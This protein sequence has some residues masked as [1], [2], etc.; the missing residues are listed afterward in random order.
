MRTA[1]DILADRVKDLP[2]V[3]RRTAIFARM[4]GNL[5]VVNTGPTTIS[6]PCVGFYPPIPG[7]AVQL[8]RTAGQWKVTGPAVAQPAIGTISATGTPQATVTIG[9]KQ[10][11]LYYRSGYTPSIGD[12]VE[13]NWATGVIQGKITG[14]NTGTDP[15]TNPGGGAT[16]LPTSP[17]LASDSGQFRSRWQGNDPRASDSVSGAWVYNG[18]VAAAL[19]GA[20][21]T[22]SEIYLPL[23]AQLGVCNIGVHTS[24]TL[25]SGWVGMSLSTPLNP[26]GGWVTLPLSFAATLA[27]GGGISVASGNGDNQWAGTQSD[28]LSGALRFQGTR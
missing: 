2:D 16:P 26:R 17:I 20:T 11:Q 6:I 15:G 13:V 9:G 19:T 25:P 10:F 24:A 21:V 7:M 14:S 12:Q 28:P 1:T 3:D 27:A 4:D 23:R 22:K 18:R 8:E 5:A